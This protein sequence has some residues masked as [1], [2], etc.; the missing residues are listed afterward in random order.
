MSVTGTRVPHRMESNTKESLLE[1]NTEVQT[2]GQR[3][4]GAGVN[5]KD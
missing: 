4:V 3:S 2:I 5:L 1:L